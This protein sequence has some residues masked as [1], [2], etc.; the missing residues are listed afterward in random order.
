MGNVLR[1]KKVVLKLPSETWLLDKAAFKGNAKRTNGIY[2]RKISGTVNLKTK[3]PVYL[4][5]KY[6]DNGERTLQAELNGKI[7]KLPYQYGKMIGKWSK[8]ELVANGPQ[9]NYLLKSVG[10][11]PAALY[12]VIFTT[13]QNFDPNKMKFSHNKL[14]LAD[15]VRGP[16]EIL[17][18]KHPKLSAPELYSATLKHYNLPKPGKV[19]FV[20]KNN[21]ILFNG[22]AFFPLGFFHSNIKDKRLEKSAVNTFITGP[23]TSILPFRERGK[24]VIRSYPSAWRSYDLIVKWSLKNSG[25]ETLFHYICD[26]PENVEVSVHELKLLN[27]VVKSS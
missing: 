11:Y 12:A 3:K 14:P 7:Y 6:S 18:D 4:W 2:L 9:I 15:R 17:V 25:P 21:N 8:P 19:S 26:E 22:K 10:R 1:K 23:R 24:T 5:I 27:S 16:L 20:D 13:D